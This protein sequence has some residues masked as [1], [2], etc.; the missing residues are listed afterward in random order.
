VPILNPDRRDL[1]R[2]S[3]RSL[4]AWIFGVNQ[5]MAAVPGF[6]CE[7]GGNRAMLRITKDLVRIVVEP[8]DAQRRTPPPWAIQAGHT[9]PRAE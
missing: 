3:L 7:M 6:P 5:A 2:T 8:R 9:I 1:L 4:A